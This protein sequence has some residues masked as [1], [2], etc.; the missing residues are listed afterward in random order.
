MDIPEFFI[1][2]RSIKAREAVESSLSAWVIYGYPC[3]ELS[4][5]SYRSPHVLHSYL[6]RTNALR[7]PAMRAHPETTTED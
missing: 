5:H 6:D 7:A 1:N 3:T 2:A 4:N